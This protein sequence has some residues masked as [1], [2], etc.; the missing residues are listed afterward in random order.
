MDMPKRNGSLTNAE[1][2][3]REKPDSVFL[4][5]FSIDVAVMFLSVVL[6]L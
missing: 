3:Y 1:G 2:R 5:T 6:E 4:F